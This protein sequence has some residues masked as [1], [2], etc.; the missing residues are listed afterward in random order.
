MVHETVP[1]SAGPLLGPQPQ[2]LIGRDE[3]DK[4]ITAEPPEPPH[5]AMLFRTLRQAS[6][7]LHQPSGHPPLVGN[8]HWAQVAV[9]HLHGIEHPCMIPAHPTKQRA[10]I[11]LP[12]QP[13]Q[14]LFARHRPQPPRSRRSEG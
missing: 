14:L 9:G 6:A 4:L 5:D 3:H 1:D 2:V 8:S 13:R 10:E 7:A 11:T 12:Q